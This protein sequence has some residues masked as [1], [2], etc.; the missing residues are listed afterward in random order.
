MKLIGFLLLS[1][2]SLPA[3]SAELCAEKQQFRIE[4]SR[5]LDQHIETLQRDLT[6]WENNHLIQLQELAEKT[7][8][9]DPLRV[10]KRSRQTYKQFSTEHCRWQYLALVPDSHAGA[11]TYK[12][13]MIHQLEQQIDILSKISY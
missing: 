12:K 4:Y 5:C 10:F 6:T 3:N 1:I 7:G 11:S 2:M 8:R 13:C 9:T